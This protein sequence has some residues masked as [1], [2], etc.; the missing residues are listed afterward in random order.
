MIKELFEFEFLMFPIQN[1]LIDG[2]DFARSIVK[3]VET[4]KK[5]KFM[6]RIKNMEWLENTKIDKEAYVGFHLYMQTNIH[7]L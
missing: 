5:K 3:Y 2:V 6:K 1:G 7:E 4:S